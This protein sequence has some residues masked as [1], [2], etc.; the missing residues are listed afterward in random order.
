MLFLKIA[1]DW[2]EVL[3]TANKTQYIGQVDERGLYAFIPHPLS[4]Y[5]LSILRSEPEG[6]SHQ[7]SMGLV[8]ARPDRCYIL[9]IRGEPPDGTAS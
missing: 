3:F 9:N 2:R 4:P 6:I 8:M 5:V 1:P 7:K